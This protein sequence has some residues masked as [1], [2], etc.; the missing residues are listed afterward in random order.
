MP[1][2]LCSSNKLSIN[3]RLNDAIFFGIQS[4]LE[5]ALSQ[6]RTLTVDDKLE[7]ASNS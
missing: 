3:L 2:I 5:V 1:I 6:Y 7:I 4:D